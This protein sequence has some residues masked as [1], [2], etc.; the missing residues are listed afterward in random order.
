[1]KI[2]RVLGFG[3]FLCLLLVFM[4]VVFAE[5]SRT[6]LVFLHSTQKVFS[7]AGILAS[8]AAPQL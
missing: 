8:Y 3:L 4:P 7:A 2:R 5:L 6:L 1:M